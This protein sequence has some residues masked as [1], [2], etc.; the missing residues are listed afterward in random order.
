MKKL[1]FC[2]TLSLLVAIPASTFA[3]GFEIA[4]GGWRQSPSGDLSYEGETAE[5]NLSVDDDLNYDDESAVMARA[6][7][8]MPMFFPNIYLMF[9]PME[10]SGDGQK[11]VN[12]TFGDIDFSGGVDFYS[13]VNLDAY[14]IALY[15]GLPFLRTATG[16]MLNVDLGLNVRIIDFEGRIEQEDTG[17]EESESYVLPLPMGY[18]GAQVTPF[19][20]I[21]IEGELRAI[22]YEGNFYYS[23]IGRVKVKIFGPVFGAVGY[24]KDAISVDVDDFEMDL[25]FGGM[26]LEAGFKF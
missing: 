14:D 13:E 5:D 12:F 10:F 7:L 4:A 11:D 16:G 19:D 9:S 17:L 8:D 6:K 1:I 26:F 21:G 15:Y 2:L 18:I 25:D 22:T 23:M 20:R 3:F 24:R